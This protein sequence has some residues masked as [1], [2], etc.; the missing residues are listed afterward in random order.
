MTKNTNFQNK[1]FQSLEV[2]NFAPRDMLG[3][4]KLLSGYCE[5]K[6]PERSK[7]FRG[8]RHVLA[9][10]CAAVLSWAGLGSPALASTPDAVLHGPLMERASQ[11]PR[12]RSFLISIDGRL[13]EERYFHGAHRSQPANIKSASKSV[14]SALV[15]IALDQGRLK[16][17]Q[18]PIG[19]FFP[20]YLNGAEG[21]AKSITIEDLLTMR[22]GLETTSN[23]NYG[24]W[25]QS[26]NWV[27]YVLTRPMVDVPGGAMIYSTGN[28]HL[29]SA[30]LTKATGMNTHE[31]ARRYLAGPLGISIPPWLRDPQGVYFGGNEMYLTPRDMLKIGELY[32]NRGRAGHKQVVSEQWIID[33]LEPRTQS[34]W[35]GRAYGYGWW[36]QTIA[37]RQASYAWGHG[38]QFLY[39]VPNLRLVVV[40]TSSPSPGE[41]RR[42]HQHQ[43]RDLLE[44]HLVPA[45]AWRPAAHN[46]SN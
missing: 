23:R 28:S 40:T 22:S 39:V 46:I 17:L 34:R 9:L 6:I 18:E 27:R 38:G 41:G 29:L 44:W 15:G 45:I 25:V 2:R 7:I 42:E 24:R 3:Q 20:Q 37:G 30:I 13:V 36:S 14:L 1:P 19:K 32:L 4:K 35:S 21:R 8:T 33:S 10:L 43:I 31:F 11:L 16:S 12:L 5:M 26:G